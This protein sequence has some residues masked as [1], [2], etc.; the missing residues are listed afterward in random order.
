MNTKRLPW[1]IHCTSD[2]GPHFCSL[3]S[4]NIIIRDKCNIEDS[5]VIDIGGSQECECHPLYRSALFVRTD[6][7]SSPNF[8]TVLDYEVFAKD[9]DDDDDDD[10]Y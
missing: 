6:I 10:G 8:F 1:A 5:C 4:S 9:D 2:N 3:N 7:P